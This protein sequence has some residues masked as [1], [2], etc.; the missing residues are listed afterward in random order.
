MQARNRKALLFL[1]LAGVVG[2]AVFAPTPE[3]PVSESSLTSSV[4]ISKGAGAL[5]SE[6][7]AAKDTQRVG[8]LNELPERGVMGD[9]KA[10]LFGPQSW[11]PPPAKVV[12]APPLPLSPPPMAYRFVG[13]FLQDG[14]SL[15]FVSKGDT[16]VAVKPGDTLDGGYVVE[17]ISNTAIGLVYPPLGHRVSISITPSDG[18]TPSSNTTP[19]ALGSVPLQAVV[20][21]P[22]QASKLLVRLQSK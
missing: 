12:A 14:N 11:Q 1:S 3:T 15:I 7:V 17:S 16:P 6:R 19:S 13:R 8:V 21:Q 10:D 4:R 20:N 9:A 5:P 2:L 22:A 18:Y